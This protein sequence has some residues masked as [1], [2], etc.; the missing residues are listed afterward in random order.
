[1]R[2]TDPATFDAIQASVQ[3][4]TRVADQGHALAPQ[5]TP[6]EENY[7]TMNSVAKTK[8]VNEENDTERPHYA[9]DIHGNQ[10]IEC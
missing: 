6:G 2:P 3:T 9:I 10:Y 5:G 8:N 7:M 1:M 4:L